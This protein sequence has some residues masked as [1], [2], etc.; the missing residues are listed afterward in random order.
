MILAK[1][2]K[3]EEGDNTPPL[4]AE[5]MVQKVYQKEVCCVFEKKRKERTTAD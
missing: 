1:Q 5:S 3:P 2:I 4:K